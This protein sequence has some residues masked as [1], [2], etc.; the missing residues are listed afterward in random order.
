MSDTKQ[1]KKWNDE[2]VAQLTSAVGSESPVSAATV[3]S[4]AESLGI[5][6]R[7]VASKLRDM[8]F[9]VASLAKAATPT[10]SADE[11]AELKALV[12]ANA[13]QFTYVQIAEQFAGGK[14]SAKQ[15]QGKLLAL[16]LTG[17]V[18]PAEKVEAA[19]T[20]SEA[21]EAK[22]VALATKGSFLE[23]IA[24]AMGK[25]VASIRG[26]AL[27]LTREGKLDAIPKQ[28][29]HVAQEADAFEALGDVSKLTVAEIAAKLDRTERGVKTML[30][31]RGVTVA[32][33]DGA[34]KRAKAD[35]KA[36]E[37]A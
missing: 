25:S 8:G 31:R 18:K 21:E 34:K 6:V 37:T 27:S 5:S 16:E 30:T 32:D 11:T 1:N 24:E 22:L 17:L 15:V 14:F 3:E 23:E 36:V 4:A 20:Y 2:L 19:R 33:Y 9:E 35:A 10:F 12:E 29:D 13:G 26:K 7:S 28:R